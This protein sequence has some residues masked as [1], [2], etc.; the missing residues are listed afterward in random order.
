MFFY[1]LFFVLG[2]QVGKF[3][4]GNIVKQEILEYFFFLEEIL[5]DVEIINVS[6]IFIVKMEKVLDKFFMIKSVI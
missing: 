1:G 2:Y 6:E 4:N 5:I 3:N